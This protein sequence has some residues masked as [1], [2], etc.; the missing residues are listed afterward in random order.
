MGS[1]SPSGVST[2]GS[3]PNVVKA[4]TAAKEMGLR[5]IAMTGS[6]NKGGKLAS[7]ADFAFVVPSTETP[8]IQEVHIT[9]GHVICQLVDECLFGS[10]GKKG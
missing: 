5:T 9:L 10:G 1:D 3:S 6:K 7:M 8:R 4:F 2:S